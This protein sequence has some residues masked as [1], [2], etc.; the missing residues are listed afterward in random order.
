MEIGWHLHPDVWG[1]GYATEA[2]RA[3][4]DDA[5]AQGLTRIIGV[6]NVGNETSQAVCRRLSMAHLGETTRYYDT[7]KDCSRSCPF[8]WR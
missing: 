3:L 7:T 2:A 5:F 4:M 6:T 8:E 1:T